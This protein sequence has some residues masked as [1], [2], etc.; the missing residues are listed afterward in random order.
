MQG[1]LGRQ[2][3]LL[4]AIGSRATFSETQNPYDGECET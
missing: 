3:G 1:E 2:Y 4:V